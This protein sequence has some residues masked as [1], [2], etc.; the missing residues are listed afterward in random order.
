MIRDPET[1]NAFL[2]SV[3]RFVKER[4]VPAEHLVA[5]TD[6]IPEGIVADMKTMGLFGLTVPECYGGL[7]LT[8]EE[9]SLV[10]FEMG[11]TSPAFRSLFGTTVGIGSQGILI[12]GT[13][14][15][16]DKYLPMLASGELIASFALTEAEAGSDAAALRTTARRGTGEDGDHY[17]INGSKRFITNAPQAGLFTLMARTDPSNQG[18]GGVSAFIVERATPGITIG[19]PDRK[20]GQ[21]GAHTADVTFDDCRV[22]AANLIGGREGMGFKTAMKVLEKG[23]IH[24]A[25]L[26]VGVAERMLE[27]ALG[28]AMQRKQFGQPIAEFQLVQA[29]LADSKMECYAARCMVVDA[30][31]RRD[32]GENVAIEASC[33][34]LFASEMCGRVADR[35]VQ[36]FGG[37]GYVSDHGIERFYRDV[38]LFRIYEGTSQI[39][40]L[41]IARNMI[42]AAG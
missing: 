40:Q 21:R 36:I 25:A 33:C 41:V 2:D 34:K 6:E 29:M 35:A 5:E 31:R 42:R 4:L 26:C 7:G 16:K 23:R 9:E 15:Q 22:P 10:M 18:A 19:K 12:D 39:Q 17:I 14:Q 30:A 32:N 37:S 3:R 27:D 24:I 38:R 8:M 1:L 20:M 11:R 13:P 28:Y